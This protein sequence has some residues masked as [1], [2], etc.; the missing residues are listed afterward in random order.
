VKQVGPL[1]QQA[2]Q[3][4]HETQGA[5]KGA[6]P[7]NQLTNNAKRN[8]QIHKASPEEQRLAESLKV[9]SYTRIPSYVSKVIFMR[10]SS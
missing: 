7:D 3:V 8:Y 10:F 1:L 2:E 5:I 9:V 6:D 4:L